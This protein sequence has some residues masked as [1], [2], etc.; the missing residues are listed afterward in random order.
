MGACPAC[1]W[2]CAFIGPRSAGQQRLEMKNLTANGWKSRPSRNNDKNLQLLGSTPQLTIFIEVEQEINEFERVFMLSSS[3]SQMNLI[4]LQHFSSSIQCFFQ[5]VAEMN[6]RNVVATTDN[7]TRRINSPE[8]KAAFLMNNSHNKNNI[9]NT[10]T[11]FAT[12]SLFQYFRF[13]LFTSKT[14]LPR[15]LRR[16]RNFKNFPVS[17]DA[18]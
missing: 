11:C 18:S 16:K 12:Q 5:D 9:G 1:K 8:Y 13:G 3:E 2:L 7:I 6:N 17:A 15:Q 14:K 4:Y 10:Q